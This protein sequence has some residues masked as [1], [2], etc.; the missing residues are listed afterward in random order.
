MKW[1]TTSTRSSGKTPGIAPLPQVH[2][3]QQVWRNR[4]NPVDTPRQNCINN[5]TVCSCT[6][7]RQ[8]SM[9]L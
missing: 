1:K 8:K 7:H 6:H 2:C 9:S 3:R 5:H 4:F